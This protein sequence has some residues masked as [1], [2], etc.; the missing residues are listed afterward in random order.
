M[1]EIIYFNEFSYLPM[2]PQLPM[3]VSKLWILVTNKHTCYVNQW[4]I[5]ASHNYMSIYIC[6]ASQVIRYMSMIDF[7][8]YIVEIIMNFFSRTFRHG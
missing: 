4:T 6:H 7:I 8:S 3:Y 1:K 5:G 2:G